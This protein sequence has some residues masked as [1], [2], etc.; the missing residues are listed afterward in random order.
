M[1]REFVRRVASLDAGGVEKDV[2]GVIRESGAG[3]ERRNDGGHGSSRRKVGDEDDALAAEGNY[4]VVGCN[5]VGV[6]LYTAVSG[7]E[8][9]GAWSSDLNEN[10]VSASLGE[11]E[12]HGLTNATGATGAQGGLSAE[13]EHV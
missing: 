13:V 1:F 2:D 11:G 12:S 5:V 7:V 6:S 4:G 3:G 8:V 10:D 9:E